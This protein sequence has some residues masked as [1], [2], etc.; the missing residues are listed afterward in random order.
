MHVSQLAG[1]R[2]ED[3]KD[4][5]DKGDKVRSQTQQ[6]DGGSWPHSADWQVWIK[7]IEI[8]GGKVSFSMKLV[9]QE[10]GACAAPIP[11]FT[12]AD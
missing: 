9:N 4:V 11:R 2:V 6:P 10:T 5:C 8:E 1:Y 3:C 7:V 12:A